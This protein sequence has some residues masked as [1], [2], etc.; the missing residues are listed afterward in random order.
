[1]FEALKYETCTGS[2]G[3][4]VKLKKYAHSIFEKPNPFENECHS[5]FIKLRNNDIT[6]EDLKLFQFQFETQED[7]RYIL[8]RDLN[9]H[10]GVICATRQFPVFNRSSN[11]K[12][13][14][15]DQKIL[16]HTFSF[17]QFYQLINVHLH[18]GQK[19]FGHNS[20]PLPD[21]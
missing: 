8:L 4:T 1:M 14:S 2:R 5:L 21:Y 17:A 7:H 6:P 20:I 3:L 18:R 10:G 16:E 11:V 15:A 9:Y 19:S 12:R 13:S